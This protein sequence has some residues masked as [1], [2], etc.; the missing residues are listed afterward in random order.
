MTKLVDLAG[1]RGHRIA[2]RVELALVENV[3]GAFR[4]HH[5]DLRGRPRVVEVGP[6]VLARHDAI[7]AAVR[8]ARDHRDLRHGR[9][10][11]GEQQLGT[12]A[13][14]AAVFLHR[15]GQEAWHVFEGD[16]RNV[17]R[18]AEAH[19]PRALHRRVDVERAGEHR[20]LV[21]D[22]ANR[23]AVQ[24][25]E[26]HQDVLRVMLMH[27]E[28]VALVHYRMDHVQ[29]VVRLVGRRRD[30]P[31]EH[32]VLPVGRVVRGAPR[33]IVEVV[34]RHEGEQLASQPEA[35]AIVVHREVRHTTRR[36]VRHRAA[37]LFLRDFLVGH[38]LEHVGAG[39]EHVARVLHHDREVGDRRRVDGAAGARAHD[40]GN[41][42][43]DARRERVAEE[44]VGVAAERHHAFL[45]PRAAR[46]VQPDD[47]RAELHRQIHDL[48]DL[49]GVGLRQRATEHRE[50]LREGEDLAAA[51][52]AVARDHPVA[53][54]DLLLHPEVA[55]AV[56]D[57][58][59]DL[60]ER[61]RI[62]Q[63]LH[64]LARGEL[65][66]LV[67]ALVARLAAAELRSALEV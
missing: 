50:V 61:A 24:A 36:V 59:V 37:E 38:R 32:L 34:R 23:P 45:D 58:L 28:E 31:V 39:D 5:R 67:L 14:D 48:H 16:E 54:H 27:F 4:S 65:A 41:L 42:R 62:E 19:E 26:A 12:V 49:G 63:Q 44:D 55:A 51:D 11:E 6:N 25:R 18:I 29:H 35:F 22:D 3:H 57:E 53:G 56:R 33:R 30:E 60:L 21:R 13:D 46:V 20:R 9:F 64:P 15:A 40:R 2:R 8:L 17:E 52:Q 43:H 1:T 47:R 10:R 7:R 66:G